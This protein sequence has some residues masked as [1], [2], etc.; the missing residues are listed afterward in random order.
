MNSIS[1]S[2]PVYNN[3]KTILDLIKESKNI[4]SELTDDYE[5]VIINDGSSDGTKQIIEKIAIEDHNIKIYNHFRNEG[6]GKTIKEVFTLPTKDLIF[7][8]PGDGQISPQELKK[9]YPYWSDYEYILGLRKKR[10][11]TLLRKIYSFLYN[12]LISIIGAT[13]VHDVNSVALLKKNA[14]QN[15]SLNSRSAFIHAEIYLKLLK[16]GYKI[17]EVEIEHKPRKIGKSGATKIKVIFF[18]IYDLFLYILGRL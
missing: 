15:I 8:I 3:E 12:C 2:I 16:N 4:L 6:F 14:L 18:T 10:R 13:R 9:L 1:I 11:D 17:K 5:I 7:F